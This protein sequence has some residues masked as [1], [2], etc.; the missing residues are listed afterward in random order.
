MGSVRKGLLQLRSTLRL[1]PVSREG[2]P[3][4]RAVNAGSSATAATPLRRTRASTDGL[5]DLIS[6]SLWP[7]VE[8]AFQ[9]VE[10]TVEVRH[11]RLNDL[12]VV[13][14]RAAA[15]DTAHRD[16]G[17]RVTLELWPPAGPRVL[18]V[19]WNGRRP[20]VVYR[21]DGDWLE[22]LARFPR[23]SK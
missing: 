7:M 14:S 3:G 22:G 6:Q 17:R 16:A 1:P 5:Q 11:F 10:D 15:R 12:Q 2:G 8:T 18:V 19:E 20:Y 13:I 9:D 23:R 21:R 4:R